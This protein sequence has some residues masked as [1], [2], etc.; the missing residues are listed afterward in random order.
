[1]VSLADSESV[2]R[3]YR[4]LWRLTSCSESSSANVFRNCEP[5]STIMM[6]GRPLYIL[7]QHN[8]IASHTDSVDIFI[9]KISAENRVASSAMSTPG[10]P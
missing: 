7:D 1:M 9:R 6:S 8:T 10:Y 5:S 2:V 4:G 3:L